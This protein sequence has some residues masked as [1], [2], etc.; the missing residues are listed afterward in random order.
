M[1]ETGILPDDA[2][3]KEVSEDIVEES[4]LRAFLYDYCV[5]STN[6]SLSRGFLHGLE[7]MVRS[8][9]LCSDFAKACKVVAFRSHG[10]KPH[11]PFLT[12]KVE[13]LYQELLGSLAQNIETCTL[14]VKTPELL[15]IVMLL[16]LYE[17]VAAGEA[18][19]G[20][21]NVHAGG[22]AA[23][24][25]TEKQISEDGL[26]TSTY[27]GNTH[28]EL[29]HLL[30]A[31]GPIWERAKLLN[32]SPPSNDTK[33]LH[34]IQQEAIAVNQRLTEWEGTLTRDFKP[35]T[36]GNVALR[37]A[38]LSSG[39]GYQPGKVD[40]YFSLYIAGVWNIMRVAR[41]LLIDLILS[42]ANTLYYK[43]REYDREKQDALSLVED[44]ISSI[45]YHLS[46]DL[47]DFLR[48][49]GNNTEI[50][51]PGRAAGGLLLM[52]PIYFTS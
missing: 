9:G 30:L 15:P 14:S 28:E 12:R 17:M 32:T 5:V 4:A 40:M 10:I 29:G 26:F 38:T 18:H 49:L 16:G 42:V 25:Q 24:L 45:P 22:M 39:V 20:Y 34:S 46:E 2:P 6:N 21:H 3:P 35:T 19:T 48:D 37:T 36:V 31:M 23:M 33:E 47:P 50:K 51:T 41:C 8:Q 13:M 11:R 43:D 1:P 52:H 44:I 7:G 27:A